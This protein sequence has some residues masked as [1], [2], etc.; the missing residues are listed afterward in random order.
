MRADREARKTMDFEANPEELTEARLECK[1]PTSE[2]IKACREMT[3]CHEETEVYTQKIEPD[4]RMMQSVAKHQ[5]VPKEDAIV[6]LVKGQKK[7]HRGWKLAAGQHGEPKEL[8]RG[9]CGSLP[10]AGRCLAVQEWHGTRET[11]LGKF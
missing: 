5:E 11:S 4:P 1:E 9:I 7:R 6:K 2:D 10:P 3:A 8:T